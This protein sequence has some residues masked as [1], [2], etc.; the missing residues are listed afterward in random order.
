[1]K[2]PGFLITILDRLHE[3]GFQAYI[4]GG[5]V[6]DWYLNRPFTDWDIATSARPE[7]IKGLFR[8]IRSFSLKH[9]TVT[10]VAPDRTYEVTTF[11]GADDFGHTLE[12]DLG[13]RDFTINAMAYDREKKAI[14]DPYNGRDDISL[15]LIRAVGDPRDRFREDPLR[16][17]RAI[18]LNTDFGFKIEQRTLETISIMADQLASIAPERI[19]KEMMKILM[20]RKASTGFN[21]MIKTDL[22]K[23][24]LPE[25]LEGFYKRQNAYHRYTIFKHVMETVEQVS[26]DPVLRLTALLHDIAKPRVREKVNGEFRF[27]GHAKEG[28]RLAE[29][30]MERLKFSHEVIGKVTNLIEHHMIVYDSGWSDGAVR[31]LIRRVGP[32]YIDQLFAFRKAD[33]LAHG[34]NDEETELLSELQRRVKAIN[35]KHIITQA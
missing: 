26:T 5:A 7:E 25:L 35:K 27:P 22:L 33:I 31:R 15:K 12:E 16:L 24:F 32:E 30:I 1:M 2:I 3:F 10:L 11:R 13:R 21:L 4:V 6:R 19:R 28:A 9:N 20:C 29:E 14:I 17:L 23:Q 18:R 8:D 34:F